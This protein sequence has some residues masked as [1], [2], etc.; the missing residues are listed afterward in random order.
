MAVTHKF[1]MSTVSFDLRP[2]VPR[3]VPIKPLTAWPGLINEH[4]DR[5]L[6][7][8]LPEELV[9]VALPRPDQAQGQDLGA[10]V[11]GRIGHR[12]GLINA[13]ARLAHLPH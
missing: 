11:L 9:D 1:P 7:L 2:S 10:T 13:L 3:E 12:D 5:S 4:E 8:E 6:G